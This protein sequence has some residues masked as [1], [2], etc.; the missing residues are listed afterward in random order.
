MKKE[1]IEKARQA[2]SPEEIMKIAEENDIAMCKEEAESI[3]KQLHT[4]GEVADEELEGVAG[5]CSKDGKKVVTSGCKCF[6]GHYRQVYDEV[7]NRG[8]KRAL[9]Y[10]FSSDGCCGRCQNLQFDGAIGYCC[11]P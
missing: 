7:I 5:G 1:L 4:S 10:Q 8:G 6:T 3:Y 2:G 11:M 9:W